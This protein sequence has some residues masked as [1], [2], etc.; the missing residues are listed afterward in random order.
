MTCDS[1]HTGTPLNIVIACGGT[2]GH[3]FPGIAVAQELKSRGHRVVL[4]ISQKKVDAQSI[5]NYCD[6]DFRAIEAIA[7]PKIPSLAMFGFGVKL[8]KAIRYCSALLDE[9]KTDV[10]IGMGGFTSFPPVYAAHR[11][12]IRAYV[13]DSNAMPGKANRMTAKW[14]NAV[15]LGVKEAAN[16]FK[17]GQQCI[18]TGTPVRQEMVELKD[19]RAARDAMGLPQDKRI[20]MVMGG[21]QGAKNLNSLVVETA[22]RCAEL[23]HFMIITGAKD[24]ARNCELTKDM[25]HV[26]VIEFCSDMGTAYA[27]ADLVI[28][29]SGASTLTE[30][31]HQGKAALLVPYPYAADDHQAHNARVFAAH[32][33]A[34]MMRES[35]LTPDDITAFLHEVLEHPTLLADMNEAALKLDT[36]DAASKI[37]NVIATPDT[38]ADHD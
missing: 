16:Y 17:P 26:S 25:P 23:C 1:L 5:K 6:L 10:V 4:L 9:L 30:L 18:V 15:L 28:S 24:Y 22:V 35:T 7:M 3:L 34:R 38:S 36:P 2:G 21:S 33:A 14:C 19:R 8:Y 32:G 13:H 37:A 31:A 20:V 27:A 12:G 29:R 11:K